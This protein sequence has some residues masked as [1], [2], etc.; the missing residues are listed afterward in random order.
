MGLVR[1]L[2]SLR[3]LLWISLLWLLT[4]TPAIKFVAF[5]YY[6]LYVLLQYL[7]MVCSCGVTYLLVLLALWFQWSSVTL[8]SLPYMAL[9]TLEPVL[10][11]E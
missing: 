3:C 11:V 1:L 8:C 2:R 5:A 7:L 4:R 9:L 10:H 6:L